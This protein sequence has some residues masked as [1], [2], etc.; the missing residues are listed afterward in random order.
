MKGEVGL[1][2]EA[3]LMLNLGGLL[4]AIGAP[5]MEMGGQT[6]VG[7]HGGFSMHGPI[8]MAGQGDPNTNFSYAT[9]RQLIAPTELEGKHGAG[10]RL[11]LGAYALASKVFRLVKNPDERGR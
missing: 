4:G 8:L 1:G 2:K 3:F 9:N 6:M 7:T 5:T 11:P 10:G